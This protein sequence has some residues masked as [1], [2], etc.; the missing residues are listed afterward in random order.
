MFAFSSL[1]YTMCILYKTDPSTDQQ[2]EPDVQAWSYWLVDN[3]IVMCLL[4]FGHMHQP[5]A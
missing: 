5:A 4:K 3:I 2:E 1:H